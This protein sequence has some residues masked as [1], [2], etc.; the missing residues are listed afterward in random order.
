MA[1]SRCD[2]RT[3]AAL[4]GYGGPRVLQV[5]PDAESAC[6]RIFT[7]GTGQFRQRM[8][9]ITPASRSTFY[10]V[11]ADIAPGQS[12]AGRSSGPYRPAHQ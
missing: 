8:F 10:A 1:M 12:D 6:R 2:G 11:D 7:C 5:G 4:P 9:Q 3:M